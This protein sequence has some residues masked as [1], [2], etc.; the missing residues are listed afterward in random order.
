MTLELHLNRLEEWEATARLEPVL[1]RAVSETLGVAGVPEAGELSVTFLG[2]EEI[3]EL[4]RRYLAKDR[5]T[6]VLAFDLGEEG[7]LLGDVYV[8]PDVATRGAAEHGVTPE[9]EVVRLVVHGVLHLLGHEHPQ[10]EERYDS[11]MFRLQEEV[12]ARLDL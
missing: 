7:G 8:S 2:E 9:E 3:R 1:R 4:N 11:P 10:G 6:D 12:V 5:P